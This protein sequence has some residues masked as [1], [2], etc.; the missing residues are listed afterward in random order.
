MT[1]NGRGAGKAGG[2]EPKALCTALLL[3]AGCAES[4]MAPRADTA[5][6]PGCG[7]RPPTM[8]AAT[9][10]L[11]GGPQAPVLTVV[12]TVADPDGGLD[13][14]GFDVWSDATADGAVATDGPP[15]W[16]LQL[17]D[18][19]DTGAACAADRR[20]VVLDLDLAGLDP[21][22]CAEL[23]LRATDGDGHASELL[24]VTVCGPG[25]EGEGD[26]CGW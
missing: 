20:P 13:P 10:V 5:A 24:V 1:A 7:D 2:M 16:T 6:G 25:D 11:G 21:E 9:A 22:A 8:E 15:T 4:A 23:A 19:G 12:T 18:L 17:P 14:L 26:D 3:L